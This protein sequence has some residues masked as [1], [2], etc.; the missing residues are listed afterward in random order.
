MISSRTKS[1]FKIITVALSLILLFSGATFAESK[2]F[3]EETLID[4]NQIKNDDSLTPKAKA[5]RLAQMGEIFVNPT[6][7]M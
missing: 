5:E 2:I 6:G 4:I 3:H 7:F 1:K